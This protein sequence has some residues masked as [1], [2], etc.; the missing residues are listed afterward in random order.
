[1]TD[2]GALVDFQQA[3]SISPDPR[4]QYNV[5][6]A[7][8]AQHEYEKAVASCKEARGMSPSAELVTKI[9]YRMDLLAQHKK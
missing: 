3:N 5:C 1:M 2:Y 6:L 7:Y 9:D 4:Y 8:E